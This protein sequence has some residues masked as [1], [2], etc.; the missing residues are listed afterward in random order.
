M[1]ETAQVCGA[2]FAADSEELAVQRGELGSNE[3]QKRVL[4]LALPSRSGS[5]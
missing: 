4:R 5:R 2:A 1:D 3:R